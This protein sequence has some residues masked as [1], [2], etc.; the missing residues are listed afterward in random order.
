MA[1]TTTLGQLAD[2][3][4]GFVFRST[5]AHDPEGTIRVVGMKD[6]RMDAGVAWDSTIRIQPNPK[7][8]DYFLREGDILFIV[9][10]AR[11][12]GVCV[13]KIEGDAIASHH[14][15]HIRVRDGQTVMP[16]FLAWQM[17]RAEAQR[18]YAENAM[19]QS[20]SVGLRGLRRPD[21]ENLPVRLP[22]MEKQKAV[23]RIVD[24]LRR[25]TMVLEAS[26]RN[27]SAMQDALVTELCR[28]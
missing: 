12:Y 4:S 8:S 13:E 1:Q 17:N 5:V 15:F 2:V 28:D 16:E 24:C 22:P 19:G 14:L 20:T 18:Y 27:R 21:M 26:I 23:M 11:F 9:R 3:R 7:F 10:G 25:E 6:L